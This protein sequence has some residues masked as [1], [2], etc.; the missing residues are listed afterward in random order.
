VRSAELG[1]ELIQQMRQVVDDREHRCLAAA[2]PIANLRN[3]LVWM[4]SAA[5]LK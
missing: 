1:A 3:E 2:E 4:P 5:Q